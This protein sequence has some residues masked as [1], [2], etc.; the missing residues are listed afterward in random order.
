MRFRKLVKYRVLLH[1][2]SYDGWAAVLS[3]ST[4]EAAERVPA[5]KLG[6][7]GNLLQGPAIAIRITKIGKRPPLLHIDLTDVHASCDQFLAHGFH[8]RD[9][10]KK[11]FE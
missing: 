3:A 7:T 9:H 8:V 10:H 11:P 6:A 4:P 2:D 5:W 1:T